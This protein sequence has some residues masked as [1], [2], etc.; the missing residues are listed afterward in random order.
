MA[1]HLSLKSKFE[2]APAWRC[3]AA[4]LVAA[5]LPLSSLR[6]SGVGSAPGAI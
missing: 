4:A 3:I 6:R 5:A 1:S 2:W